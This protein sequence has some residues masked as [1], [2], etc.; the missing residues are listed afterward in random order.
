MRQ[1]QMLALPFMIEE[2]ECLF[3]VLTGIQTAKKV[4][5]SDMP[6]MVQSSIQ[7]NVN[8]NGSSMKR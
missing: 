3:T 8:E 4:V 7:G 1:S 6:T 5:T 2:T